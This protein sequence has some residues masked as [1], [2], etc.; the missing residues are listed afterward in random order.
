MDVKIEDKDQTLLLLCSLPTSYKH[1]RETLIYGREKISM[2]YVKSSLFSKD[3]MDRE[4]TNSNANDGKA[5][6][7]NVRGRNMERNSVNKSKEKRKFCNYCV[8]LLILASINIYVKA[9][10]SRLKCQR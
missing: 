6:V 4:L 5:E 2:D 8:V 1:L 7:F 10:A 9:L 3:L